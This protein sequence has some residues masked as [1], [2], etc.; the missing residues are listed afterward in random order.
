MA[1]PMSG[2]GGGVNTGGVSPAGEDFPIDIH[3]IG[4]STPIGV[5]G[6]GGS[7]SPP[8]MGGG[9]SGHPHMQ[10]H[11]GHS[12]RMHASGSAPSPLDFIQESFMYVYHFAF[13]SVLCCVTIHHPLSATHHPLTYSQTTRSPAAASGGAHPSALDQIGSEM[14][15]IGLTPSPLDTD[16]K[17]F[18]CIITVNTQVA[19][20]SRVP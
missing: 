20:C 7:A 3:N 9:A 18:R 2:G 10:S 16:S 1:T 5:G 15:K 11:A 13:I 14:K 19:W 8:Y 6:G 12:Q 4:N 17:L